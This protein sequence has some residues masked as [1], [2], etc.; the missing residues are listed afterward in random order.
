MFKEFLMVAVVASLTLATSSGGHC[1]YALE[2]S[3]STGSRSVLLHSDAV[4]PSEDLLEE[5]VT[6]LSSNFDL[7][8]NK[9]RPAIEF[10]SRME[11]ARLRARDLASSQSFMGNDGQ[12]AQREVV[13]LYDNHR[14]TILLPDDWDSTSPA[15]QSVLVH[16]MVHHLQNLGKLK[17]DCPQAR[18][19]T[20]Y[21]AQAKWLER[22]GLSLEKEFD[23]DMFP[24]L[25]SS[26]C[27]Y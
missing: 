4:Q 5:I 26:A 24:V 18:E 7:P 10:A 2:G 19:N 25:I 6:W 8:A 11:L 15:D 27:M 1:E 9:D 14:S 17:F 16:E 20:A 22:F 13:A 12:A 21:L 3:A 23:V